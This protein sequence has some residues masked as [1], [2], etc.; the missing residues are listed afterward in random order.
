MRLR[1]ALNEFKRDPSDGGAADT[2]TGAFSG[3]GDRLVHVDP[4]G[5]IRDYSYALSG[6]YGVDR[7]RF[8]IETADHTYWF[9][10]LDLVRQHYYRETTLVETEYDAGRFTVHQYDI[11]LGRAHVTHVELRGAVPPEARLVAFLTLAPEGRESR[12]GRLIHD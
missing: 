8:G 10:D 9:D 1:T 12:V 5:Q 3:R 2:S 11:T 6:L 4:R 7:S